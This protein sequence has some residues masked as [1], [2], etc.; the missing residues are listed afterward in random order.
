M[1]KGTLLFSFRIL[2]EIP[3]AYRAGR[4]PEA[5]AVKKLQGHHNELTDAYRL[6]RGNSRVHLGPDARFHKQIAAMPAV[7]GW[8]PFPTIYYDGHAP[9]PDDL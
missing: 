5:A 9:K 4:R 3:A 8:P 1:A 7:A 2:L 6:E